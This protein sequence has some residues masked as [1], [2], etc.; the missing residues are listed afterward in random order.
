MIVLS[1]CRAANYHAAGVECSET[2]NEDGAIENYNKALALDPKRGDTLYNL[3][4]IYKYRGAWAK[5]LE[6]NARAREFQPSDEATLWKL[7]IAA[8]ALLEWSVARDV[9]LTLDI[10]IDAGDGP[11][12]GDFGSA[13]VRVNAEGPAD[14]E[15]NENRNAKDAKNNFDG[16]FRAWRF[17]FAARGTRGLFGGAEGASSADLAQSKASRRIDGVHEPGCRGFGS[18]GYLRQRSRRAAESR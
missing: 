10:V 1:A 13:P 14:R 11:I 3:G 9:W 2:G 12:N 16:S 5:S 18:R 4:L 6:F 8:T 15:L 17:Y 7:G